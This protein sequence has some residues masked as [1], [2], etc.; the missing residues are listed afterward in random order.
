MKECFKCK[1]ILSLDNFYKHGGMKDGYVNKC[2][3]C[4]KKDVKENYNVNIEYFREYDKKRNTLP[5][6]IKLREGYSKTE[7]YKQSHYKSVKKQRQ[8]NPKKYK[9]RNFVNNALKNGFLIKP[10]HCE[11]CLLGKKL[12]GHHCDYNKP[13]DVMW[14][15]TQC[16][17]DWH[18]NNNAI[19]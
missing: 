19:D 8:E 7:A 5:H 9:A 17:A 10:Q 16:H 3:E 4:N 15:C 2:K 11:K 6:R 14:L 12:H 1:K 13:L 18:K